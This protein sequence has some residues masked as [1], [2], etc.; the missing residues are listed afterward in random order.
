MNGGIYLGVAC[1]LL[2]ILAACA[3]AAPNPAPDATPAPI[4]QVTATPS[5]TRP[6]TA[7][8]TIRPTATPL[9][10]VVINSDCIGCP[11]VAP[12]ATETKRQPVLSA[13]R[14]WPGDNRHP[15]EVLLVACYQ[16]SVGGLGRIMSPPGAFY[17]SKTSIIL[18]SSRTPKQPESCYAITAKYIGIKEVC[19]EIVSGSCKFGSGTAV[20]LLGF[21]E[22][23]ESTEISRSQ[24]SMLVQYAT[25]SEYDV[26]TQPTRAPPTT[27]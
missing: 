5:S 26:S 1:A 10:P 19:Q 21:L 7:T 20:K 16:Y 12:G 3:G 23:G 27:P 18:S 13:Y 8:P 14:E 17:G 11:V 22:S 6:P 25:D 9:P 24:Y 2:F 4:A 15:N